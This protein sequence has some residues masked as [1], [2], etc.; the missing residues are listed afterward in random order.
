MEKK[1]KTRNLVIMIVVLVVLVA[2]VGG[3]YLMNRP[4]TTAGDKTIIVEVVTDDGTYEN[5]V[6]TDAEYLGE[7]LRSEGLIAGE[8]SEYGLFVKTVYNITVDDALEQW[9]CLTKGGEE[10][11]T[12][13]DTTPI[14]DGDTFEFT[15]T[16]GY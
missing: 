4:Q 1:T 6:S 9:W 14:E 7:A 2:V 16:T 10:V 5:R 13:V 11:M 8:E 12:G 15:L 3:V